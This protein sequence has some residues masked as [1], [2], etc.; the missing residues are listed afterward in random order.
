MN[1]QD[2]TKCFN[3]VNRNS[4]GFCSLTTCIYTP[5]QTQNINEIKQQDL[6]IPCP[7]SNDIQTSKDNH[8]IKIFDIIFIGTFNSWVIAEFLIRKEAIICLRKIY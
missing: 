2:F 8:N 7:F 5:I 3:C 4:S 1:N 6:I